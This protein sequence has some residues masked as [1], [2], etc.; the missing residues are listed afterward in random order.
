[1]RSGF[2]TYRRQRRSCQ[3]RQVLKRFLESVMLAQPKEQI[4]ARRY[5]RGEARRVYRNGYY[6]WGLLSGFWSDSEPFGA[7]A[8]AGCSATNVF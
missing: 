5:E 3:L 7:Q 6:A 1:M 8:A 2:A 4:G